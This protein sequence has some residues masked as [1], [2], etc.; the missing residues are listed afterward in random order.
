M[1]ANILGQFLNVFHVHSFTYEPNITSYSS[2]SKRF[3][4]KSCCYETVKLQRQGMWSELSHEGCGRPL[5]F[6]VNALGYDAPRRQWG[7]FP[8]YDAPGQIGLIPWIWR[9]KTER[10]HQWILHTIERKVRITIKVPKIISQS[11]FYFNRDYN[12]FIGN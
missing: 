5:I 2:S 4:F 10:K 6:Q 7:W 1:L 8:G 9:T 11:L 3:V 12:F